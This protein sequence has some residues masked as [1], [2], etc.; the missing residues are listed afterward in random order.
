[1]KIN[2]V[3]SNSAVFSPDVD[4]EQLKTVGPFWGGWQTWRSCST[5]NVV[6]HDM[7]RAEG[8]IRR[9]FQQ[10]CN[11]FIPNKIYQSL[12]RPQGVRL[13][14]GDFVDLEVDNREDIVAMHLAASQCDIVLLV[15][16]DLGPVEKTGDRLLDHRAI[17]YVNLFRFAV[18]GNPATQWVLLDH[19]DKLDKNL[20]NLSNL[21]QDTLTNSARL[22]GI[23]I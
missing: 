20:D 12:N 7:S 8:L 16:F 5:D 9:Q 10:D 1:M 21:T 4:I 6:C 18:T 19:A 17:N 3:L 2:W 23:D 22:L 13:Y 11:F 14:D 15:G